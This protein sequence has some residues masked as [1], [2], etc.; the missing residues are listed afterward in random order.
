MEYCCHG[1][2]NN[3]YVKRKLNLKQR[4]EIMHGVAHGISYLHSQNIIHRDIKPG[5]IIISCS[6]PVIPKLTDFGLRKC[7]DPDYETSVTSSN[8][9]TNAFKA[10]E[11]FTR[12]DGKLSIS[13]KCEHICCW[14]HI[15]GHD[16]I[17][18]K[19]PEISS[20]YWN[21]KAPIWAPCPINRL[22]NCRKNQ[23]QCTR[24]K[25]RRDWRDDVQCW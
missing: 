19:V 1:D 24:I 22:T 21:S 23:I 10:P 15:F 5:N 3:F 7:L 13:Q 4:M 12:T 9:G 14:S 18:R 16:T 6:F 8:V 11:F 25:H 2:L 20:P 17:W